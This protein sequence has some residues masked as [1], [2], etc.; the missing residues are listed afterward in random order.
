MADQGQV[1]KQNKVPDAQV[2]DDPLHD[3]EVV[4]HLHKGNEED[5]CAQ[6]SGKEPVPREDDVLIEEENGADLGL[7]QKVGG[8][9]GEPSENF[10]TSAGL[11]DKEGDGL[12]GEETDDDGWPESREMSD[13]VRA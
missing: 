8:E 5:D 10:E 7:F 2:F 4:H 11:E 6:N 1:K 12:L 3:A 13:I 9:E